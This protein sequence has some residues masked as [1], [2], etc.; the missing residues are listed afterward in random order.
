[1]AVNSTVYCWYDIQNDPSGVVT[2]LKSS[3]FTTVVVW[4][5]HIDPAT[6]N[7]VLN[8]TTIVEAQQQGQQTVSVYVGGSAFSAALSGIKGA[9]SSVTR[10]L[11]CIASAPPSNDFGVVQGW[12]NSSN[13]AMLNRLSANFAA[14]K[15]AIPVIDGF[16]FDD[17]QEY[18]VAAFQAVANDGNGI[19]AGLITFCPYEMPSFWDSAAQSLNSTRTGTVVGANLQVY[20]GGGG[21][22]PDSWLSG[23]SPVPVYPLFDP[24][25]TSPAQLTQKLKQWQGEGGGKL[26]GAGIWT[27]DAAVTSGYTLAAYAEAI[28]A[29]IEG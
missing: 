23:L 29:G 3:G 9:G 28:A 13:T 22:D 19:G 18:Q 12:I 24:Q 17:E 6:A 5:L 10:L 7:L 21:N 15:A 26:T 16:D 4:T 20:A 1:M 11:F 8:D 14:L 2:N 25:E 27:Y